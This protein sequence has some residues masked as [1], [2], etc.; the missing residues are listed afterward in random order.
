MTARDG[1]KN[2]CS[3]GTFHANGYCTE[4]QSET[5]FLTKSTCSHT[6][7]W[8]FHFA[9]QIWKHLWVPAFYRHLQIHVSGTTKTV[10]I[11]P[12]IRHLNSKFQSLYYPNKSFQLTSRLPCGKD[13]YPS[14]STSTEI[15]TVQSI[16]IRIV[17]ITFWLSVVLRSLYWKG[18]YFGL[19]H[20]FQKHAER[21][22]NIITAF[23]T[24]AQQ[25]LY[26]V[27]G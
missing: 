20:Y 4:A 26:L 3:T 27:G 14:K 16:D 15:V 10:Q 22:S 17:R 9:G 18:N 13:A 24:P 19:T 2:V 11:Y 21:N 5:V 12:I 7:F 6:S 25:R 23:R 8:F 1:R